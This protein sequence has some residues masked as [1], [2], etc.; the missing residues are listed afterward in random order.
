MRIVFINTNKIWGGGEKWHWQ[1]ALNLSQNKEFNVSV[2]ASENSSLHS[3]IKEN[4]LPVTT[5]KIGNLSFLNPLKLLKLYRYFRNNKTNAV[6]FGLPKDLKLGGLAAKWAGV[7]KIIYA[8][9]LAAPVKNTFLNKFLFLSVTT[10]VVCNSKETLNQFIKFNKNLVPKK[11]QHVIYYGLHDPYIKRLEK[12]E[13][14]K[15]VIGNAGRLTPQKAQY[16]F[17]PIAQ[18]LKKKGVD[19]EILIAGDGELAQEITD[20]IRQANLTSEIKLLGFVAD[21]PRFMMQIDVFCLTS[22]WEGFGYVIAE[23]HLAEKPVVAFRVSSNPEVVEHEKDGFL[24]PAQN[25]YEMAEK[26]SWLANNPKIAKEM[27]AKGRQKVLET[28]S[29]ENEVKNWEE[30]LLK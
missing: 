29:V 14:K 11:K 24:V 6:I 30:L 8:R 3:K 19:F 17:I 18:E 1:M 28:F 7:D 10:H 20:Q 25:V 2:I 22:L 9:A 5:I 27:G 13:N 21:V 4:S 12:R 23:A 15:L 26:I 16:L